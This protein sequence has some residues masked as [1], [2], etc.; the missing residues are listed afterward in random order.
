VQKSTIKISTGIGEN[1]CV[2]ITTE[3]RTV[4]GRSYLSGKHV[5]AKEQKRLGK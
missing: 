4:T 2:K 3:K 1:E 5:G